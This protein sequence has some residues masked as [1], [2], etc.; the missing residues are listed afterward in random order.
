[1]FAHFFF[2][3]HSR[4]FLPILLIGFQHYLTNSWHGGGGFLNLFRTPIHVGRLCANPIN[5][6]VVSLLIFF[7]VFVEK[8]FLI[9]M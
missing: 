8:K 5:L 7:M 9:L 3:T 2:M 1:M 6:P 4:L